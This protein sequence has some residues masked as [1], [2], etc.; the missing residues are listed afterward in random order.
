MAFFLCY[1]TLKLSLC[2]TTA[3]NC[4]L[5]AQRTFQHT[6]SNLNC[7]VTTPEI[8]TLLTKSQDP[9]ACFAT[10]FFF[11]QDHLMLYVFQGQNFKELDIMTRKC[12][13]I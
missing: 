11:F 1:I 3:V 2:Q 4:S 9:V 5:I 12:V 6:I 8:L 10:P 13:S 7:I